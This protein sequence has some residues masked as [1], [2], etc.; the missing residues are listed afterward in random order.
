VSAAVTAYI[1][2]GSNLGDRAAAIAAGV[3]ALDGWD[4]IAVVACSRVLE[5][6]PVGPPQGWY[7]NA[8]VRVETMLAASDLL[9]ACLRIESACGRDRTKERRW[10]PRRLDLDVLLYGHEVIDAPGLRVPHPR[11]HERAFVLDPLCELAPEVVHPV[12]GRTIRCLRDRLVRGVSSGASPAPRPHSQVAVDTE[13]RAADTHCVG[14][15]RPPAES[16]QRRS[17]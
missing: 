3:A 8:A 9:E 12:L 15:N 16:N 14:A 10:G 2:L 5:T 17:T 1:A 4:G 7:C 13:R 6:A 11:M